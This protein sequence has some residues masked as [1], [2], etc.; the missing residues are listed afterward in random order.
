MY[1]YTNVC[2]RA[3]CACNYVIMPY[4]LLHAIDL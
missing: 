4:A 3:T 1:I 2:V